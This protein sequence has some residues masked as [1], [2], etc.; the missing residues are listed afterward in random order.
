[1]TRNLSPGPTHTPYCYKSLT[2]PFL[3]ILDTYANPNPYF[4]RALPGPGP[5]PPTL[6]TSELS[7]LMA[8]HAA[9]S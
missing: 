8:L 7:G 5:N 4:S 9:R 6:T 1:M 2:Q 3:S